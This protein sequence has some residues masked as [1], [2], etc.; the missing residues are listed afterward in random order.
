MENALLLYEEHIA[1]NGISLNSIT[2]RY[3]MYI[4]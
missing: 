4:L 1:S 2:H 3:M